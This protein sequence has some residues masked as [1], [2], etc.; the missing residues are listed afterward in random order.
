LQ[1]SS[2]YARTG[3]WLV[4]S[5]AAILGL[6]LLATSAKSQQQSAVDSTNSTT[7]A[8]AYA[9]RAEPASPNLDG[10][11]DEPV[12]RNALVI[13]GF[14]QVEPN[15][16]DDPTQ[17]TEVRVTYDNSA[18]YVCAR[19]YD[20]DPGAI[21]SRLGR[22]DSR[23]SSDL[24]TMAIDS[25]HD[26]RTAF[27]FSVNPAG[28]R[29]DDIT[30][31]DDDYGDSSWDPVWSVAT[32]LDSLGWTAE[33]RIP[34]SQL[35]FSTE[36]EQVWGINFER[37]TFRTNELV[38]WSWAPNTEQGFASLFGHLSGLADIPQP[39][40]LEALPYT[41]AQSDF[42][43][44]AD[45]LNP[46]NDGSVQSWSGGLDLK[47]GLTS[48]L[49]LDATIN[50]DFGQVEVDPA[51]VNLTAFETFFRERRPFF[52]EGANLFQ[53]GAGSGGFVFGAPQLFYSRRIG[54]PPSRPAS[55]PDGFVH[56]PNATSILGAAK[57]SGKT[58]GWSIG[59]LDAVTS[60]EYAKVQLEDGTRESRLAEPGANYAV[61]SVRRDFR[62]GGTGVGA[63][64][65]TVNR[66][67]S[68]P[69]FNF[70]RS[71]AYTGGM[72]FF[73]RFWNNQW[74]LNGSFSASH[75]RGDHEAITSAQ[76]SSA[77]YFQRPD[78]DYV[79]LDATAT[80]MTGYA[81]SIQLGK[82]SGNWVYGT[83][84]YAYSPGLEVNDAGFESQSD[85]IFSGVRVTRRWLDPGKVF[86]SFRINATWAQGWNFGGVNQFREAYAGFGGQFLN[87]WNF[88]V[89]G[90][91]SFRALNDKGTRGGPLIESPAAW[92]TSA[93]VGTD[94]RKAVSIAAFGYYARNK[95]DGWGAGTGVDITLRPTAAIDLTISPSYDRTHSIGMYVTQREDSTAVATY[96]GRYLFSELLQNSF[97]A[98]IRTDVAL[99]PNLTVQW[100]LQPFIAT[101]DYVRFKELAEPRTYNFLYYGVD[102]AST[103]EYDAESSAYTVDP[104]GGAGPA[105]PIRFSNPDFRVRSL[106]SNLV[107]RWEYT[108]GSTLFFVW[109]H[110]RSGYENEPTLNLFDEIGSVFSDTMQNTFLVKFN[111]WLSL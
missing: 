62:D 24:F 46:F 30:T 20:S 26:H 19:M 80:S 56:N 71:A 17:R 74:V 25:Y 50:P 8:A 39:R 108:P 110:G 64:A 18:L 44:G 58:G 93:F 104:D 94:H 4:R 48:D 97:D 67:L 38:R 34:F 37:L 1:A 55:E 16:G 83:D 54:R 89:G 51:V 5:G 92:N 21:A 43:E 85:R 7:L 81:T 103:I 91:Y 98:T 60:R 49:T 45:P 88:S 86:R 12:W 32:R 109:N 9:A 35:R 105:E 2:A 66:D 101:G 28:V 72:D 13:S 75:I 57:L 29:S 47:Y 76:L 87:Y 6:A 100:Y 22:R 68:D 10:K 53:F 102:G 90:N 27:R 42:Q 33:I 59:L 40:R 95:Y 52:V 15:D 111:Y 82:V 11:L 73:H 106:R 3:S 31:N 99:S 63:L 36:S 79:S 84:F 96:G 41:L 65:T 78:Q 70:L 77:R 107:V 61:A 23:T 14:T 69:G